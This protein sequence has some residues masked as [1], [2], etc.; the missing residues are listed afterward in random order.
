MTTIVGGGSLGLSEIEQNDYS[1]TKGSIEP[2]EENKNRMLQVDNFLALPVQGEVDNISA[3]NC[4]QVSFDPPTE[5]NSARPSIGLSVD[6]ETSAR[7]P[8]ES[9]TVKIPQALHQN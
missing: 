5:L 8:H 1:P 3:A 7:T 2:M 6:G 4:N 9:P